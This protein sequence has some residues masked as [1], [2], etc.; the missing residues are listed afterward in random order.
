MQRFK[1]GL[2]LVAL[3]WASGCGPTRAETVAA[4]TPVQANGKS[5]YDASCA[6]CHGADGRGLPSSGADLTVH[7]YD[8]SPYEFLDKIIEGVPKTAMASFAALEDQQLADVFGYIKNT[9][10][11]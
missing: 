4:L 8:H 9:L 3:A 11:K 5:V 6:S 10:A 2:T 7:V 1:S